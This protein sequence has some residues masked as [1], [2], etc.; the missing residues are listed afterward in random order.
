MSDILKITPGTSEW[1]RERAKEEQNSGKQVTLYNHYLGIAEAIE[2]NTLT[3]ER[4][5][6]A[7]REAIKEAHDALKRMNEEW[8][9]QAQLG[10]VPDDRV[11]I[12]MVSAAI[13]KLQSFL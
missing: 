2:A 13:A 7:M 9:Y 4:E 6:A 12:G 3:L 1:Y 10:N 5:N 11:E 8:Q